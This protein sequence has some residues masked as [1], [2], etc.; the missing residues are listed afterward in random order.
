MRLILKF[1]FVL[2]LLVNLYAQASNYEISQRNLDISS[3]F[4]E[5]ERSELKTLFDHFIYYDTFAYALFGAKSMSFGCYYGYE[6]LDFELLKH[7]KY[8]NFFRSRPNFPKYWLTWKKYEP[9]ILSNNFIFIEEKAPFSHRIHH[10]FLINKKVFVETVNNHLSIF[11]E[12][13]DRRMIATEFIEEIEKKGKLRDLLKWNERLFGIILGFGDHNADLYQQRED[14]FK[15]K[16]QYKILLIKD[17]TLLANLS[18]QINFI[19]ENLKQFSDT[20]HIPLSIKSMEF[21]VDV[22]HKTTHLLREKYNNFREKIS[23]IYTTGDLLDITMS[24]LN[25]P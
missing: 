11:Q 7:L 17:S 15:L 2:A 25:N 6:P 19:T 18:K 20:G 1:L 4:S 21:G 9:K 14:L 23:A 24:Q 5:S 8:K 13:L 10:V 22:S 16:K 3:Q 12:I